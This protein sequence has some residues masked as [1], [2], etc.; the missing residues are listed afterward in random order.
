MTAYDVITNEEKQAKIHSEFRTVKPYSLVESWLSASKSGV[1]HYFSIDIDGHRYFISVDLKT[2]NGRRY[3]EPSLFGTKA[4]KVTCNG[5]V[6]VDEK[7]YARFAIK[8]L[9][10]FA[11]V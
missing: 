1:G 4:M 7:G 10:N 6:Y 8:D 2:A 5:Y 3:F 9:N 11:R